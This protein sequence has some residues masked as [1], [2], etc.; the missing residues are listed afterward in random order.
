[1]SMAVEDLTYWVGTRGIPKEKVTLGLPFYGYGFGVNAPE[2]MSYQ[3]IVNKYPA[4][5]NVDQ[6]TVTGG[7]VIYYNGSAT[8][9]DKTIFALKNAGGVMIW[10][11]LQ[12]AAGER[13]LLKAIHSRIGGRE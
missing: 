2:S 3:D 12:D 9:Q 4:S 1:M 6:L 10:Q 13:S 5:W 8:I 7:G 11:L